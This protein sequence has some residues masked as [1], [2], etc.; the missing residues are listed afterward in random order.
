MI[1][2]IIQAYRRIKPVNAEIC[3]QLRLLL[4]I[5]TGRDKLDGS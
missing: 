3:C 2:A 1:D 5:L 4:H